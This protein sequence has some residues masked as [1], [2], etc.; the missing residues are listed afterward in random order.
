MQALLGTRK[1]LIILKQKGSGWD[2]AKTHF[3]GVKVSYAIVDP[4]TKW[5]WAGVAHGHWGPKLHVSK[6]KG[7][8]FVE[9]G[10]PKFPEQSGVTLKDFWAMSWDSKGRMYIGTEP[11][12]VFSSDDE[13]KTWALNTP[14]FVQRGKSK[15][16]GAGTDATALHS[17]LVNPKDDNHLIVGISVAGCL[18]SKNRGKTWEY[19]NLGLKANF[20]PDVDSEIGQEPHLVESSPTNFNMLW[21]QN[22][23]GIFKSEDMGKS[24]SDLSANKG[25]VSGFGWAIVTDEKNEKIAYTIPALSDETRVPTKK[26]LVVQKTIDGGKTWKAM[27]KGLPQQNCYD[28]V[29]RHAFAK[30]EK[31][32]VFGSTTGH[33][34]FSKNEGQ[35]WVQLKASL[36][37]VY[38]V[39][40]F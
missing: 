30:K 26:K 27:S 2:I 28:I 25:V 23:C 19:I 40:M 37:P 13:G 7:K 15:W 8:T 22:H 31:H 38:C 11:A 18:E 24:W 21:Q 39:K 29:Y 20:L 1:G 36:P 10:T 32:L 12:A 14:L 34:Y 17:L 35:S 3:D 16:F 33:V 6:D 9:V 5:I 4:K